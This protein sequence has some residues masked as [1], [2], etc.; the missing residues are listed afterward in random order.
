MRFGHKAIKIR[1]KVC[2]SCH[3]LFQSRTTI[4][5]YC[6]SIKMMPVNCRVDKDQAEECCKAELE[7]FKRQ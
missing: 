1:A 6:Q 2:C 4:C 7:K 5:P 3:R